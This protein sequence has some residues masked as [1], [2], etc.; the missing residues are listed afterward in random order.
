MTTRE[1]DPE[2]KS[3]LEAQHRGDAAGARSQCEALLAREP[4]NHEALHLLGVLAY[5]QQDFAV[6][7]ELMQRAIGIEPQPHYYNNLGNLYSE[8]QEFEKAKEAYQAA[9]RLNPAFAGA[10]SNLGN[11]YSRLGQAEQAIFHF[12]KA[13]RLD[14][15]QVEV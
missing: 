9:L 2:L 13:L 5:Q 6:A 14:P 12:Q 3:A 1:L 7:L 8:Q 10:C 15:K 11:M 4:Q